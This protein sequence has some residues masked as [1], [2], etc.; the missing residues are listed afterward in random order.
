MG[1]LFRNVVED[2]EE[3]LTFLRSTIDSF[4]SQHTRL[5]SVRGTVEF[6]FIDPV[7]P[8]HF[9]VFLSFFHSWGG[10]GNNFVVLQSW[11][12]LSKIV[13]DSTG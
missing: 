7:V 4:A 1:N 2:R 5:F 11:A 8:N 3:M 6:F 13:H 9:C 10:N 12:R